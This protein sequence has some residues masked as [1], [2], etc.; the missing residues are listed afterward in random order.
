MNVP[1]IRM[2]SIS[3]QI[4]I[5]T[6]KA[7]QSIQQPK[8]E[9]SIEQPK[10]TLHIETTP[11]RL[12]IDQTEAWADMDL[13][14]VSRRIQEAVEKGKQDILEGISRRVQEG[15]Q[16]KRIENGGN[17]IS[18]ISRSRSGKPPQPINIRFIPSTG[19]VK[20]QYEPAKVNIEV[21]ENKPKIEVD[22][23]KPI[24]DFTPGTVEVE[25][26]RYND[27]QIDFVEGKKGIE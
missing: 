9:L 18:E 21:Q 6:N 17:P 8:A 19:S 15:E 12:T 20:I 26:E 7:E 14:H 1:Q 16:L 4:S 11:S 24:I 27:L 25:L 3:A 2:Q 23:N 10:A 5:H 13:K 22:I